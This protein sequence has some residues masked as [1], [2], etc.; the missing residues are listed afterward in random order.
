[1]LSGEKLVY[2]DLFLALMAQELYVNKNEFMKE[3]GEEKNCKGD[4]V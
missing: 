3:Y 2:N 4:I 1:M